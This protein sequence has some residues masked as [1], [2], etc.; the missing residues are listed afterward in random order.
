MLS[1]ELA[2]FAEFHLSLDILSVLGSCII[3]SFA[4][5]ALQCYQLYITFFLRCHNILLTLYKPSVGIGPTTPSLP[6]KCSTPELQR[7]T[8]S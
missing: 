5:G 2:V 8:Y 7:H 3:L 6:W 4:L 1:V